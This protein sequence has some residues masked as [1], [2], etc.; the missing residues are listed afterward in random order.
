MGPE[1]TLAPYRCAADIIDFGDLGR[2]I[3]DGKR[4][5]KSW[6]GTRLA[7]KTVG[8]LCEGVARHVIEAA[9]RGAQ[10]FTLRVTHG[11]GRGWHVS[12]LEAPLATQT[13]RQDLAIGTPVLS[14]QYE[15]PGNAGHDV[16]EPIGTVTTIDHHGVAT[17]VLAGAGGSGYAGKPRPVGAPLNTVKTDSRIGVATPVMAT[18]GYGE[19]EGQAPRC[20]SVGEPINTVVAGACK[21]GVATPVMIAQRNHA[22]GT[23]VDAPIPGV[24]AGGGHNAMAV[25]VMQVHRGNAVG[26]SPVDPLATITAGNGPGRGA[27]AGH[28]QGMVS[29]IVSAYYEAGTG[30]GPVDGSLGTVVTKDRHGLGSPVMLA[31]PMAPGMRARAIKLGKLLKRVLGDRVRLNAEGMALVVIDGAELV[32]VD[33]LFRMLRP[34]ELAAAMGFPAWYWFPACQRDAV[35]LIGNAVHVAVARALVGASLPR[36]RPMAGE[37]RAVA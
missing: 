12:P 18:V 6:G 3:Y 19:R 24:C 26:G 7:R 30:G 2:S 35:R 22:A 32:L 28:A 5:S 16:R 4:T 37:G 1:S 23:P 13:T 9:Q 27:G 11:E 8:R 34:R 29:P 15:Y 10:P 36:L 20:S 25:P 31:G 14:K 17:P 21:S 33:I